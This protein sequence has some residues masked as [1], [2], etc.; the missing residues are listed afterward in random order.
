MTDEGAEK[1]ASA[2]RYLADSIHPGRATARD[3][4]NG[5][6]GSV[7]EA[8]MG[9]TSALTAIAEAIEKVAESLPAKTP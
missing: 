3:A 7:T 4:Q 9:H 5:V 2:I 8:M 6:V 1:I